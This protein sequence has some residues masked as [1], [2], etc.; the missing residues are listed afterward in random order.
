MS[1]TFHL[2]SVMIKYQ[3]IYFLGKSQKNF[4][5]HR[6]QKNLLA[7][8]FSRLVTDNILPNAKSVKGAHIILLACALTHRNDRGT[9]KLLWHA[10]PQMG[11]HLFAYLRS[12]KTELSNSER[13]ICVDA[14]VYEGIISL[15]VH[16]LVFLHA[17]LKG[18]Y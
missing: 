3:Q 10:K 11:K 15:Q 18:V 1:L 2:L 8:C 7:A 6:S 5:F 13:N 4:S 16:Y 14:T 9:C 12:D 17:L